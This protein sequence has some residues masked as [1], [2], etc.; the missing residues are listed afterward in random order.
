MNNLLDRCIGEL[1]KALKVVTV[2]AG[3]EPANMPGPQRNGTNQAEIPLST[4]EKVNLQG[5]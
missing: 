3:T 4:T 1:D 5:K 2:R